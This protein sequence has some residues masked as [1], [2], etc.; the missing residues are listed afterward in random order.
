[1][2]KFS[3]IC[4]RGP[5]TIRFQ[6]VTTEDEGYLQSF[7]YKINTFIFDIC[8]QDAGSKQFEGTYALRR[9]HAKLPRIKSAEKACFQ[10]D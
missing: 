5:P 6:R 3:K 7:L 4:N 10:K 2:V 8:F 1:M 9:A